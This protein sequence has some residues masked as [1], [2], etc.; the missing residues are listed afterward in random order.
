MYVCARACPHDVLEKELNACRDC[1]PA[2]LVCVLAR[3]PQHISTYAALLLDFYLST[4]RA[5]GRAHIKM[6]RVAGCSACWWLTSGK[7]DTRENEVA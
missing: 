4:P 5:A 2:V 6:A 7:G 1:L 3:V